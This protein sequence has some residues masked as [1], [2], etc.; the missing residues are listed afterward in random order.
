MADF[1][2]TTDT[3]AAIERVIRGADKELTLISA[4]VYPRVIYLQRLKDAAERGVNITFIFG[5]KRMDE[6]VMDLLKEIP[7][8]RIYYLHELHAKCF[9]NEQEAIVTSLNLL[10]GSE[11]KNREMGVRL[12]SK[13]DASAYAECVS[14]VSSILK[15]ATLLHTTPATLGSPRTRATTAQRTTNKPLPEKGFCIRCGTTMPCDPDAPLCYE[16]FTVWVRYQ[17]PAYAEAHCHTCGTSAFVNMADPL[18]HGCNT[19]YAVALTR[20]TA[21]RK[22]NT[23]SKRTWRLDK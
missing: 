7:N 8:L 17:D 16:D 5:K 4:Y 14:E 13:S 12:G 2:T 6:K 18:C 21:S 19:K 3:S 9:V 10:N 1:L 11:E 22:T 20:L 15:Q 23:F